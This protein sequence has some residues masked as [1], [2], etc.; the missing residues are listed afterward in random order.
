MKFSSAAG[1]LYL[2]YQM[3]L[4][5]PVLNAAPQNAST[6]KSKASSPDTQDAKQMNQL[7][8]RLLQH[9]DEARHAI[10]S[11]QKQAAVNHIN[12][13]LGDWS[14]L[15]SLAK[16]KHLG[17]T[18]PLYSE[19]DESSTLGPLMAARKGNQQSN[20]KTTP[21]SYTPVTVEQA[22]GQFT[23][24]GLDLDKAKSRLDAAKTALNNNNTQAASDSLGAVETDLVMESEQTNFPLLAARE[25]LGIAE[26]AVKNGHVKEA[27]AALKEAS[28]DLNT[29]AGAN[30]PHHAEDAK[31]LSKSIESYSQSIG[32]NRAGA[33][34]KIDGWWHEVDNW[35]ERSSSS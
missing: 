21:N 23:F 30:P 19:F 1:A 6:S 28:T 22:S 3:T 7:A 4:A 10:S 35:F 25:N 14:Q 12:Q 32:Q 13:A 31:T 16:S 5:A 2:A 33:A 20:T 27:A 8:T 17:M 34:T 26:S 18:V 29:F 9:A 24:I 11:N 15:A